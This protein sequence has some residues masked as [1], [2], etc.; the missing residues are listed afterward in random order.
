MIIPIADKKLTQFKRIDAQKPVHFLAGYKIRNNIHDYRYNMIPYKKIALKTCVDKDYVIG[1]YDEDTLLEYKLRFKHP[2]HIN[3]VELSDML[4]YC[5]AHKMSLLVLDE[6][7]K[8]HKMDPY[9]DVV[10]IFDINF[11]KLQ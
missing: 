4:S 11:G 6:N 2:Y 8:W 7:K 3:T 9:S 5:D 10:S 1:F